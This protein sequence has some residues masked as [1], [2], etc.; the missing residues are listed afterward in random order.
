[1]TE[2]ERLTGL[3]SRWSGRVVLG[4]E[5]NALG[6]PRY[7]GAKYWNCDIVLHRSRLLSPQRYSTLVHEAF[8]SVSVGLN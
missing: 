4:T 3:Q 5:V 1:M 7:F 8:H 6:R 2:V